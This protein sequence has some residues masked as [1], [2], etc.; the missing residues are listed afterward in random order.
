[1]AKRKRT[2]GT[3]SSGISKELR[4]STFAGAA[5]TLLEYIYNIG[6]LTVNIEFI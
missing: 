2:T 5:N 3:T 4:D 6:L 1:M